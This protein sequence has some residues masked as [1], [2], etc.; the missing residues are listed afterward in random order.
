MRALGHGDNQQETPEWLA[1]DE[2]AEIPRRELLGLL[3]F[4]V[5]P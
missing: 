4:P 5:A 3:P 2:Q 1:H